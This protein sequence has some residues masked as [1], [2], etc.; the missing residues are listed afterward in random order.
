MFR[1][2]LVAPVSCLVTVTVGTVFVVPVD[3]FQD[4]NWGC[5]VVVLSGHHAE[6]QHREDLQGRTPGRVEILLKL[7]NSLT[8]TVR[9]IQ[10]E[11]MLNTIQSKNSILGS[12]SGVQED[13][14]L[15]CYDVCTD[16]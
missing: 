13:G 1:L 11:K 10:Q 16:K 15:G 9:Y 4:R 12:H 5:L 3:L 7:Q 8:N 14:V 6:H 2:D